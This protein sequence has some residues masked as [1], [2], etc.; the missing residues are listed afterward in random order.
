V[1]DVRHVVRVVDRRRDVEG[2]RHGRAILGGTFS[3]HR[4]GGSAIV[5]A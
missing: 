1:P 3:G 2:V 4:T 5:A